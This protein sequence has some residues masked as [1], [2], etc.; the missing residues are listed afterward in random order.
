MP[1]R[2]TFILIICLAVVAVLLG[3]NYF[4]QPFRDFSLAQ[5]S[6][7]PEVIVSQPVEDIVAS[8]WSSATPE[9]KI[10]GLLAAPLRVTSVSTFSAQPASPSNVQDW[11]AETKPGFVTLFGTQITF[12][13][14]ESVID[15]LK[16]LPDFTVPLFVAVDH[17]GGT[18]QRLSGAGFTRLPTWR[19]LCLLDDQTLQSTIA[20]S[21]AELRAAGIDV[22]FAPDLDVS[23]ANRPL[24]SRICSGEAEIVATKGGIAALTMEEAGLIPVLKHFPGIGATTRD[25]H[26]SFDTVAISAT[27][28]LPFRAV[29]S[30][31]PSAAV[32]IAP[33][34][35]TN[36]FAEIPCVLSEACIDQLKASYPAT[37]IYSDA[38]EMEAVYYQ[39]PAEDGSE[40]PPLTLS[41]VSLQALLAGNDVLVYGASVTTAEL[42]EVIS[43]LATAYQENETFRAKVDASL[44][45]IALTKQP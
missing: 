19:Q 17:E 38:L 26:N 18:V 5:P 6:P 44:E 2:S 39:P 9:E 31:A 43:F 32:M 20:T 42:D 10:A 13:Q 34:G 12:T 37:L 16:S 15:S 1:S 8:V 45:K 4:L 21:S 27:D 22:V 11:I 25:L 24:Q 36:Q 14:A 7:L 23:V 29:L 3:L 28:V 40:L 33:V 35:V 30:A 41:A